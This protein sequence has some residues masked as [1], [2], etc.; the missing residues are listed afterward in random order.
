MSR[1]TSEPF[2]LLFQSMKVV[3]KEVTVDSDIPKMFLD[4][5]AEDCD[6]LDF[7]PK[8]LFDSVLPQ[9]FGYM[10]HGV[11]TSAVTF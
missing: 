1:L 7:S 4:Y 10:A 9:I 5:E 6:A 8:S 2:L 11:S 3:E